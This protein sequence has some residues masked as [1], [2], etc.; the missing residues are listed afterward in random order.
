MKVYESR[1]QLLP[2]LLFDNSPYQNNTQTNVAETLG[3]QKLL[4][5][6]VLTGCIRFPQ[7]SVVCFEFGIPTQCR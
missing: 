2:Y 7:P 1:S 6:G 5:L 4:G 3:M